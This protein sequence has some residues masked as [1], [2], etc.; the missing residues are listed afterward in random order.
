MT[1]ILP[2]SG[3]TGLDRYWRS[4]IEPR[5]AVLRETTINRNDALNEAAFRMG[6]I[7]AL[8]A[9]EAEIRAILAQAGLAM[10]LQTGEVGGPDGQRGTVHSGVEA[11]KLK[12][13]PWFRGVRV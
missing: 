8:G 3:Y 9:P 10:G 4:V 2:A 1:P 6:Q 12:P 11:G 13:D 5:L 7:I